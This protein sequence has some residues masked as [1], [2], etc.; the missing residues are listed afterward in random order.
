MQINIMIYAREP[1]FEV[2]HTAYNHNNTD[3]YD[4]C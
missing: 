3:D 1:Y 2:Y 4:M